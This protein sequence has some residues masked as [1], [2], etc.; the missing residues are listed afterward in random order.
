MKPANERDFNNLSFVAF[1]LQIVVG[2]MGDELKSTYAIATDKS[3]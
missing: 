3:F 1:Q 2:K